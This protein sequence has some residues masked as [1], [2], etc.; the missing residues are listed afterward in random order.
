MT[1]PTNNPIPSY[2][3]DDQLFNAE[4]IDQVVNSDDLEYSD[5]FGKK[6]FTIA[7]IYD[8]VKKWMTSLSSTSGAGAIGLKQGGTVQDALYFRTVE[9]FNAVGDGVVDDAPAIQLGLN[10]LASGSN[11]VLKFSAEKTYYT[12]SSLTLTFAEKVIGC[13][14]I[15]DGPI[16]PDDSVGTALLIDH[17]IANNF[18][19]AIRGTGAGEI[20]TLPD[21]SQADPAE[22]KQGF[23]LDNS[24]NNDIEVSGFGYPGRVLRTQSTG[25]IKTSNNRFSSI[26]TGDSSSAVGTGRCGQACY[27]QGGADAWGSITF[28]RTAWD[29]HGSVLEGLADI[30]IGHWEADGGDAGSVMTLKSLASAHIGTLSLGN[31]N[32]AYPTITFT[33]RTTTSAAAKVHI[34]R[35]F[36][37][38]GSYGLAVVGITESNTER[39]PLHISSLF[40]NNTTTA[41]ILFNNTSN[42]EIDN[43][44]GEQMNGA[45]IIWDGVCRN[46]RINGGALLNNTKDS[47][48][49]TTSTADIAN[50]YFKGRIIGSAT[51]LIDFTAGTV[52][53]VSFND[54]YATNKVGAVA[55]LPSDNSVFIDGGQLSGVG[56]L[57][58]T[59]RPKQITNTYRPVVKA[60]GSSNFASG[61]VNLATVQITH[62]LGII[63]TDIDLR[64]V[65]TPP[66][67]AQLVLT[68]TTDT[69]FTV[70]LVTGT[71]LPGQV[72]FRWFANANL[73]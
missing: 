19:L 32:T 4:K 26:R 12:K 47:A 9:M 58:P 59:A 30:G 33:D 51:S 50:I 54:L 41:A 27:L 7:G 52:G 64:W 55:N 46:I 48:L 17:S 45:G 1:L 25:S 23:V 44:V 21:Y 3:K 15:M 2:A 14:L 37:T 61:S 10:W 31:N 20:N 62:G 60:R 24:R 13:A 8:A 56:G 43:A 53:Y 63:P 40:C 67:G 28:A 34:D 5:R 29:R 70:Q 39:V 42:I 11:R 35:L 22:A 71:T 68:E 6:R 73:A 49:K 69:T 16:V 57:F 66:A 18:K 65:Q 36:T 38:N 72:N